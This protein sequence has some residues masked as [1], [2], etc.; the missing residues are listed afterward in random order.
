MPFSTSLDKIQC[1][2]CSSAEANASRLT[3]TSRDLYHGY[4]YKVWPG[5]KT[6]HSTGK[7]GKPK[8]YLVSGPIGRVIHQSI[9]KRHQFENCRF[10]KV[11]MPNGQ[12]LVRSPY[13]ALL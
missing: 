2:T 13:R 11:L 1:C 3:V 6:K 12:K 8:L 10:Y 7:S 4:S 5:T 9:A